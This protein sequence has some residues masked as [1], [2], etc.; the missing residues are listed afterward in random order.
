MSEWIL[1]MKSEKHLKVSITLTLRCLIYELFYICVTCQWLIQDFSPEGRGQVANPQ[2]WCKTYYLVRFLPKTLW[3]RKKFDRERPMLAASLIPLPDRAMKLSAFLDR[4]QVETVS[5][6]W[7]KT[8][9]SRAAFAFII[10]LASHVSHV[11][12]I[13]RVHACELYLNPVADP[14]FSWGGCQLS[15]YDFLP[16]TAWKWTNLDPQGACPWCP[17]RSANGIMY[18]PYMKVP[19]HYMLEPCMGAVQSHTVFLSWT[20]GGSKRGCSPLRTKIFLISCS[21]WENLY[22]GAFPWRVGTPSYGKPW[23]RPCR[24]YT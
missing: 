7:I 20:S 3:K 24:H 9:R 15:K 6:D 18:E 1:Q 23:T 14:G 22:V 5:K 11:W 8:H 12:T 16:K 2:V 13:L 19:N 17:L 10:Y 21:F 4:D